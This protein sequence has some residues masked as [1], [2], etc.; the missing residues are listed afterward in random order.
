MNWKD[1]VTA[2]GLVLTLSTVLVRGGQLVERQDAANAKLAELTGQLAQLRSDLA[3]ADRAL[4][5]QRGTDRLH[6]EQINNLRR[7]V[8]VLRMKGKP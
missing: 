1:W 2:I 8:D 4:E 5:Q 6:D 3:S 7:D